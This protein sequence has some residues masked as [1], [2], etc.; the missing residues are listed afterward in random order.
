MAKYRQDSR[1][2]HSKAKILARIAR[3]EPEH[4]GQRKLIN[5]EDNGLVPPE[6]FMEA[7]ALHGECFHLKEK[8]SE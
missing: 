5:R 7:P 6:Q 3:V 4:T 2:Q 8:S 1:I